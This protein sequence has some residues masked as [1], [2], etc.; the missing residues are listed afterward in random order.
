LLSN[1]WNRPR[2]VRNFHIFWSTCVNCWVTTRLRSIRIEN[3]VV[4]CT[5]SLRNW[6]CTPCEINH[7]SLFFTVNGI[8][9][10]S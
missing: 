7:I 1:W 6:F 2:T 3:N 5:L 10:V 9:P 8:Q 4:E